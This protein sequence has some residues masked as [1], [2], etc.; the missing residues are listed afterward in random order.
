MVI[1]VVSEHGKIVWKPEIVSEPELL[2]AWLQD[3]YGDIA[4]VDLEADPC[5]SD[6]IVGRRIPRWMLF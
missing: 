4:A 3:I 6:C 5:H 2:L 1:C